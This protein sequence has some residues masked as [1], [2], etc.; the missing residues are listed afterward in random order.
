VQVRNHLSRLTEV[1]QDTLEKIDKGLSNQW[2]QT[3]GVYG[4]DSNGR[5]HVGLELTI[6]WETHSLLVSVCGKNIPVK[7][8][9]FRD[10][11]APEVHNGIVVFKQA[12]IEEDLR[13]KWYVYYPKHL[14]REHINR[15]LG[16]VTAAPLRWAGQTRQQSFPVAELPELTVTFCEAVPGVPA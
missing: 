5:V 7:K 10:N 15:E 13:T 8:T 2:L 1:S 3:I 4:L 14:D 12:V 16:F 6:D 11:L 9:V